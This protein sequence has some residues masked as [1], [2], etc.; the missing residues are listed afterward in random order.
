MLKTNAGNLLVGI[1]LWIF[2]GGACSYALAFGVGN[3]K[4]V[5]SVDGNA[6]SPSGGLVVI[7]ER[8]FDA[9]ANPYSLRFYD[10][11]DLRERHGLDLGNNKILGWRWIDDDHICL[12]LDERGDEDGRLCL[13]T[14]STG[15]LE[16]FD[17]ATVKKI[18][19]VGSDCRDLSRLPVAVMF[20]GGEMYD[21][22]AVSIPDKALVPILENPGWVLEWAC[23]ANGKPSSASGIRNGK[24]VL[25]AVDPQTHSFTRLF[26]S[27]I[28][29]QSLYPAPADAA[30][31]TYALATGT[32]RAGTAALMA[33][34][35]AGERKTL[36]ENPDYDLS[37]FTLNDERVPT[38][39]H[40]IAD[41]HE[42]A[43][44]SEKDNAYKKIIAQFPGKNIAFPAVNS[45]AGRLVFS[46]ATG[47]G[48]KTYYLYD[49]G[50]HDWKLLF[51]DNYDEGTYCYSTPFKFQARDGL[52]ISGYL[53]L[54]KKAVVEPPPAVILVH[55]G[56]WDM[57]DY[58]APDSTV[59][60]LAQHGFAVVRINFRG[61]PGFG[62]KFREAGF[63][64]FG[65]AMQADL[66]DGTRWLMEQGAIS[67]TRIAIMGASYGGYA[68]IEGLITDSDLYA[69]GIG[70]SGFYDVAETFRRTAQGKGT[71]SVEAQSKV[72][73]NYASD[74]TRDVER[75]RSISPAYHADK[76]KAPVLLVRGEND[77]TT[78]GWD[79]EPIIASL[80][81]RK[82]E[83][84]HL[85]YP[86]EGHVIRQPK[87]ITN[88][89]GRVLGFLERHI[90][91][92]YG[93]AFWEN[94]KEG[95]PF[96]GN[97]SADNFPKTPAMNLGSHFDKATSKFSDT[98]AAI[99]I[100][101]LLPSGTALPD[102]IQKRY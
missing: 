97:A 95:V 84:S 25:F 22:C 82:I 59:Q 35:K 28:G 66:A 43:F 3:Q 71:V 73:G 36:Y 15:K 8:S 94:F 23:D 1:F 98:T 37:G 52:G 100:S 50:K 74:D 75:F 26:E 27:E 24:A 90:G 81:S 7:H 41:L 101:P 88:V 21:L 32:G 31:V 13:Y 4:I 79:A 18:R 62:L 55:G 14:L 72:V 34:N 44:L 11:S 46:L 80:K 63:C 30:G 87:N 64:Q 10:T 77:P 86:D 2:F 57:R 20:M 49:E 69:C 48:P 19:L 68:A 65:R 99:D 76:I 5:R 83:A 42:Y 61:S 56:P 53:T 54:P 45:K 91:A 38:M 58:P 78:L 29:E 16:Y 85:I 96:Q 39:V 92:G 33:I 60:F 89:L 12:V 47:D 102:K 67:K 40:W 17:F 51:T 6:L 9:G 93:R 70:F